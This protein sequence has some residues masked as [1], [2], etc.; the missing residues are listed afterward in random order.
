MALVALLQSGVIHDICNQ[1]SWTEAKKQFMLV[2]CHLFGRRY[3]PR[4]VTA[5]HK[6]T[7]MVFLPP[8]PSA[9]EK[10]LRQHGQ[11]IL[12]TFSGYAFEYARQHCSELSEHSTRLPLSGSR[13]STTTT[14][15]SPFV[16]HLG[17]QS[18]PTLVRCPFV[19]TSGHNDTFTSISELTSSARDGL[20][21]SSQAIPSMD[22]FISSDSHS[23]SIDSA[24]S[25]RIKASAQGHLRLNA[26]LYDFYLHGQVE[27]LVRENGV[28]RGDVWY[29]LDD[30]SLTLRTVRA[31]LMEMLYASKTSAQDAPVETNLARPNAALKSARQTKKTS[32]DD[33]DVSSD[34]EDVV[35]LQTKPVVN[36]NVTASVPLVLGVEHDQI[37]TSAR[38]G[39]DARDL[40]DDDADAPSHIALGKR[41]SSFSDDDWRVLEVVNAAVEEFDAAFKKMWA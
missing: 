40:S 26:Y 30:F 13:F 8:L 39:D 27:A 31:A 14:S 28:R 22:A 37:S 29:A 24:K 19:A 20:H 38:N 25:Y 1:L 41:P 15:E 2:M 32:E 4:T 9:A 10:L 23:D 36:D 7:S 3:L 18:R 33:W 21:L 5:K 17:R 11:L 16:Q 12:D 35:A 34:E 6:S